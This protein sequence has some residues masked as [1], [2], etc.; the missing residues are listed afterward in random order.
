MINSKAWLSKY[1]PI[2][3]EREAEALEQESVDAVADESQLL[4]PHPQIDDLEYMTEIDNISD[5]EGEAWKWADSD[6]EED[7]VQVEHMLDDVPLDPVNTGF[8]FQSSKPKCDFSPPD[9][10]SK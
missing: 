4:H 6:D 9:L 8:L 7:T 10:S 5:M 1:L 2:F 3:R